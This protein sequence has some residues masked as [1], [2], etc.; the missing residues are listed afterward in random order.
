MR[1]INANFV[2]S[3]PCAVVLVAAIVVVVG[4]KSTTIR[5]VLNIAT[6]TGTHL[7][8]QDAVARAARAGMKNDEMRGHI[9]HPAV[10]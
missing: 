1:E 7:H 2:M 4:G 8:V 5:I 3:D 10:H 6:G 9:V